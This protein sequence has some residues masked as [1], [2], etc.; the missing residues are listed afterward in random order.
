MVG[1]RRYSW[2]GVMG[3]DC[4]YWCGIMRL[5]GKDLF[6]DQ[7]VAAIYCFRFVLESLVDLDAFV[8]FI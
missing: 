3:V 2:Y 6:K 4:V 1:G 5:L 7:G 8:D